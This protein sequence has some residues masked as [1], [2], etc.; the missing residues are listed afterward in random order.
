MARRVSAK[1]Y[2]LALYQ[3]AV[4]N[5]E[6]ESWFDSLKSYNDVL[7]DDTLSALLK[8]PK[9]NLNQKLA[10]ISEVMP[11]QPKFIGNL[12][13][14]L[15][16]RGEIDIVSSVIEEYRV[17]LDLANGRGHA[18]I[19]SAVPLDKSQLGKLG[20]YL[21]ELTGKQVELNNVVDPE[22]LAG[23]VAR[24]GDKLIDGSAKTKLQDLKKSLTQVA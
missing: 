10:V 18:E 21:G 9:V 23:I 15:I 12:L 5:G 20:D 11:G 6:V 16:T 13:G 19:T 17:L 3:L 4:E 14:I 7:M 1:R 8:A 22:V 2:A 24:I